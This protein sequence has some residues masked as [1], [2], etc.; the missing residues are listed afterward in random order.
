L[1][2]AQAAFALQVKALSRRYRVLTYDHRGIGESPLVDEDV[3]MLDYARDLRGLLDHLE[4]RS[5]AMLGLSF[6]GRV[7][8]SF[9]ATWP[10]RVDRLVLGCTSAGGRLH[11]RGAADAHAAL[12]KLQT[13]DEAVW[14]QEIIPALFGR[15]YLQRYPERVQFF[16][17]WR[18]KYPPDP[19]A[20]ARQWQAYEAFDMA[21]QLHLITMPTL[22]IHGTED[23]I[24]PLANAEAL[25]AALPDARLEPMEGVGHSPNVEE[26]ERFNT[27]LL[28]FLEE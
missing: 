23:R 4:L 18:V 9:A 7:L 12:R 28:R 21:E 22:V 5:A 16:A 15:R 24:S 8:Q 27:L 25:V 20:L 6:G 3:T 10:E 2:G 11:Q 26:P 19:R 13:R 1:G 14:E 17:R